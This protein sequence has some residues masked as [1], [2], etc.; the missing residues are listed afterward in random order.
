MSDDVDML[1]AGRCRAWQLAKS[2]VLDL[3]CPCYLSITSAPNIPVSH[4]FG[5]CLCR[6]LTPDPMQ[7]CVMCFL[8]CLVRTSAVFDEDIDQQS[9][10]YQDDDYDRDS[11]ASKNSSN[12]P[13]QASTGGSYQWPQRGQAAAG[14]KKVSSKYVIIIARMMWRCC[15][16]DKPLR[17][18]TLFIWWL[19]T[20]RQVAAN[21][22]PSQPTCTVSLLERQLQ[23][24][25]RIA[26]K[27]A[28]L[29]YKALNGLSPQY[30]ADDC[31]L[32]T[33][34]GRRRLRQSNVATCEVPRTRTSLGDWSF[35]TAGPRLWNN[36]P[37]HL[38]D[39]ELWLVEFRRLLKT[40]LFG[41]G[42]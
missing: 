16:H 41:W 40:H 3:P 21:P 26:F 17:E 4:N 20:Q 25:Q 33:T 24:R 1:C 30:L 15:H 18:F 29:V 34:T 28:V 36:L 23:V 12:R 32:I 7:T 38:R 42:P 19:Q 37:L 11:V 39:F 2:R 8:V 35:T 6:E 31:Q 27:M 22:R 9:R 5:T 10:D 13:G 14:V